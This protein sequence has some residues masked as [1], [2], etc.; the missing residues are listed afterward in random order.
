M[1]DFSIDPNSFF[2][3]AT[4]FETAGD[5]LSEA[6]GTLLAALADTGGMA[7]ADKPGRR[8]SSSYDPAFP[9]AENLIRTCVTGLDSIGAGLRATA[10]NYSGADSAS[11]FKPNPGP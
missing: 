6:L 7:G 5:Q 1:S 3:A 2:A 10:K 9:A 11:T 4:A 8:F